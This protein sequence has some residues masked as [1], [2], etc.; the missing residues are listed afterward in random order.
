M[1]VEAP[2]RPEVAAP[3]A[4]FASLFHVATDYLALLKPKIILLL[5][6]TELGAMIVAARGW[7]RPEVLI[8]ALL[9]GS[10]AAGGAGAVNCWFDRDIDKLMPRTRR[11][12]IAAGRITPSAGLAYGIA[13]GLSGVAV[14]AVTTNFMAAALALAGG[15]VY[16]IVYTMWL[17]RSTTQNIVI[18]GA[19]GAF[20]PLV[21]WAAVTG[22][23]TPLAWVLFAIIF[24]WTP[25]H[26]WA[27]ALL[28]SKQYSAA[29]VPM[30][31]V[32]AGEARTR[33][34]I[35]VYTVLLFAIS[36]VP[37]VWLGPIYAVACIALGVV[38][39]ALALR[40]TGRQ[41]GASAVA[42]F[43]YSLAYLALLFSAAA[44]AAA[45]RL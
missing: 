25:P 1:A 15:L 41:D 36:L 7:P 11:R 22:S 35:L 4:T 31:P 9:G 24:F 39:V 33:R 17:K 20:P 40:A 12:A 10:M 44:L 21:G 8:G 45:V 30:L 27:L 19:A 23:L 18:G 16:V 6:V 43:H 13:V 37:V 3:P 28:L 26:F 2:L 29:K 38:F 42:L 5:V 32:I 14:I 34:S